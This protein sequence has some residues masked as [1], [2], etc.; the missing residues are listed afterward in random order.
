[1]AHRNGATMNIDVLDVNVQLAGVGQDDHG[2][3]LVYLPLGDIIRSQSLIFP[4]KFVHI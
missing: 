4:A 3:G 1:M 2:E